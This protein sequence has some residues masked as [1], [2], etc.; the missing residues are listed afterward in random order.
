MTEKLTDV[1]VLC[2]QV[3]LQDVAITTTC[4]D[5]I[6]TPGNGADATF[7]S[8]EVPDETIVLS[9]VNLSVARVSSN[10]EMSSLLSPS[11]RGD[12]IVLGDLAQLTYSLVDG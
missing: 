12:N 5:D 7:V 2:T 11:Y 4:A 3:A 10:S 9:V 8:T 6:L 1:L